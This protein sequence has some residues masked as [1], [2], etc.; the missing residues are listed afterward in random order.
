MKFI[1]MMMIMLRELLPK[2]TI[3]HLNKAFKAD[4]EEETQSTSFINMDY[5][6]H[7]LFKKITR[8][9]ASKGP[10]NLYR[11]SRSPRTF[12]DY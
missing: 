11:T 8:I 2:R 3:S 7:D 1:S 9:A 10:R 4:E 5:Q 6:D 12:Q